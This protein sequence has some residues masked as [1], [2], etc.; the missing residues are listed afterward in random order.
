MSTAPPPPAGPSLFLHPC[1]L[2]D[3]VGRKF[4]VRLK[5]LYIPSTVEIFLFV[6][7]HKFSNN[8]VAKIRT[9]SHAY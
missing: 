3:A 6:L 4:D 9:D 5:I 1:L 8:N 7:Y 2:V